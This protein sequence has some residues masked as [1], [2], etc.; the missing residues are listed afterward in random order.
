M[1]S[2]IWHSAVVQMIW[3]WFLC[4]ER[5]ASVVSSIE[6]ILVSAANSSFLGIWTSLNSILKAGISP[7]TDGNE[8]RLKPMKTYGTVEIWPGPGD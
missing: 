5:H 2:S 7:S 6:G 4:A 3:K 8:R 1:I